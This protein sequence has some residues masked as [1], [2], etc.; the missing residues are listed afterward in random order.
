MKTF[1]IVFLAF[2]IG[3]FLLMLGYFGSGWW[4]GW[5]GVE[6]KPT[7]AYAVGHVPFYSQLDPAWAND[8]VG[9]SDKTIGNGDGA[10]CAV[11]ADLNFMGIK[12]DPVQLNRKLDSAKAFR[13]N[14]ELNWKKLPWA[15]PQIGYYH[16][17]MFGS[18]SI[19]DEL[20]A[21][22]LP[23]VLVKDAAKQEHW[24]LIVGADKND[25]L[26]MDPM[27]GRV[28]QPLNKYGKVYAYRVLYKNPD[29]GE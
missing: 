24:L 2:V 4:I 11:A 19:E 15:I 7:H 21:K 29:E 20:S 27:S 22:Q 18:S 8:P 23:L 5:F 14:G 12:I 25:F 13:K 28:V 9:H 16:K 26:V 17:K 10:V 6:L 3:F 1:R